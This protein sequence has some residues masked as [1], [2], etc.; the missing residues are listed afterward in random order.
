MTLNELLK[1]WKVVPYHIWAE[2]DN[3]FLYGYYA[4]YNDKNI[5]AYFQ[6]ENDALYF[7]LNK[8][9]QILNGQS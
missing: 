2:K 4:V 7:L 6:W 5:I 8:I 1:I 3:K 9:N